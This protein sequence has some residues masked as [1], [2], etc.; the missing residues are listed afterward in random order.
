MQ[1][2]N[3]EIYF[4][5]LIGTL[6]AFLLVGFILGM[7]FF[8]QKRRQKQERDLIRL[9]KE[10]EEEVLRSQLEIQ[11][12]T[13]KTIAQELHDNIGQSLSV[14]K[15][16]MSMAPIEK[17]HAAYEGVQSSKEMLYKVIRDMADL[18]KSLHTDRISDIGLYESVRFDLA[19]IRRAGSLEIDFQTEGEEF[20]FPDQKSIFIF[21]MYQEMMN[22]I[23]KHSQAIHVKV[24]IVYTGNDTFVLTIADDGVGFDLQ[25]K[26]PSRSGSGGLGLKNM[27]NR[28]KMIGA[29]LSIQTEPGKGTAITVTVP[30]N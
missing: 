8:Y 15:L 7:I 6:L 17:D 19:S 30:L 1:N 13:M 29:D 18:T 2:Q 10:Y 26:N 14:I 24:S 4:V 25:K 28:A 27:E 3:Q 20:H 5:I 21:R 22:N 23:I 12:T 9:R 11:E 16:W